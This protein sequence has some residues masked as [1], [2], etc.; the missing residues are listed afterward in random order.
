MTWPRLT[1]AIRLTAGGELCTVPAGYCCCWA[2][3]RPPRYSA[4]PS[5][6]NPTTIAT[7]LFTVLLLVPGMPAA[8]PAFR[9]RDGEARR[10][11]SPRKWEAGSS[12]ANGQDQGESRAAR[13]CSWPLQARA[14]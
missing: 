6:A 8:P 11:P 7:V 2:V 4:P 10:A 3:S 9:L 12:G 5:T 1:T 13:D 14:L